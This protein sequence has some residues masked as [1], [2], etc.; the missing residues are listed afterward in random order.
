M[1]PISSV[2]IRRAFHWGIVIVSDVKS[3]GDIPDVD[4]DALVAAN[5]HGLVVAVRHAQDIASFEGD[6]DWAEAEVVVR[7]L[8]VRAPMPAD[9]RAAS[10]AERS[11]LRRR[12]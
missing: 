10:R 8:P 6:F 2:L 9:R 7:L 4:R 1:Q 3:S 5:E 11:S 12:C